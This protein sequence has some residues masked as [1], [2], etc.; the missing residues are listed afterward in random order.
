MSM[1][2]KKR[3]VKIHRWWMAVPTTHD[4]VETVAVGGARVNRFSSNAGQLE[5]KLLESTF[6][7]KTYQ[8]D[9]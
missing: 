9:W 8:G 4:W 6:P 2:G 1:R 7:V 5:V 3:A